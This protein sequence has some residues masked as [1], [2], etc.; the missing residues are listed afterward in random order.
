[1]IGM[2][3]CSER[4]SSPGKVPAAVE[5]VQAAD[6]GEAVIDRLGGNV[7][8]LS[9]KANVIEEVSLLEFA[10]TPTVACQ[11]PPEVEEAIAVGAEGSDGEPTGSLCIQEVIH[12][13]DFCPRG[14]KEP[15]RRVT[16]GSVRAVGEG[17]F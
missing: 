7:W 9:L 17:V 10:E 3:A 1:M 8:I 5:A 11:P 12:R 14:V 16:P 4:A 2:R 13:G 15:V 6:C